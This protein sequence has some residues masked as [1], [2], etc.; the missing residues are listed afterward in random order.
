[1][2]HVGRGINMRVVLRQWEG[3][4]EGLM[5]DMQPAWLPSDAWARLKDLGK[6]FPYNK[7]RGAL[8]QGGGE[9]REASR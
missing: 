8:E 4:H 3:G 7:V 6:L 1:M 2:R 5:A 9:G